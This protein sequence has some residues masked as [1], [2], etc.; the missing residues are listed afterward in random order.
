MEKLK[1]LLTAISGQYR[2]H[3]DN[4]KKHVVTLLVSN[5]WYG[6]SPLIENG[7]IYIEDKDGKRKKTLVK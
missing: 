3:D 5:N 4:L 6:A 7:E 2:I 1:A